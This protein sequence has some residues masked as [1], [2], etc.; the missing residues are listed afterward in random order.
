MRVICDKN[1]NFQECE[2]AILRQAVDNAELKKK[3]K[4]A[5]SPDIKEIFLIVENFI[6]KKKLICYGG[7]A[8]NNILPKDKQFYDYT[9]EVPDYDFFS[10]NPVKDAKEL[11]N[12]YYEQGY[13]EVEAKAGVHYGTYKVYVNFIPVADIT[14]LHRELFDIIKKD[15]VIKD[16]IYYAPVNFLRMSMY[17]ELSRPDGDTSRWEKILK[18]MT[19]LN[20]YYPIKDK[21]CLYSDFQRSL[22][23]KK[24]NNKKI[25]ELLKDTLIDDGVVFFGGY[26]SL[27][28]SKYMPKNIRKLFSQKPDFDVLSSD[29]EKTKDK[30]LK[31]LKDYDNVEVVTHNKIGE[32]IPKHYEIKI[33]K[34]TVLFIYKT[35]AC[36]NY[37][38]ITLNKKIIKVATIETMLSLY[39]AFRYADRPYYDPDRILCLSNFLYE[40]QQHNRLKQKGLLKRFSLDCEGNQPT[41]EHIRSEKN[42]KYY[43]LKSNSRDYEKWFLK[44]IPSISKNK[45]TRKNKKNKT[46]K[47]NRKNSKNKTKRENQSKSITNV[48]DLYRNI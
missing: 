18:R 41:L 24:L 4:Q 27:L 13:K 29:A 37:N 32:V 44:Y 21:L 26:A 40:V 31:S 12:I 2:L 20:K 46:Q 1:L 3:K 28:Y 22:Y 39:L 5:D 23:S 15:A 34:D 47:K 25:F 16:N 43:Q 17:L 36:H 33:G 9:L 14:L 6:K 11:A 8:I 48:F 38:K 19:L 30:V 42:K 10:K 35:I 7:T 45:L